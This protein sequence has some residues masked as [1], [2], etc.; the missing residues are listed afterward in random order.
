MTWFKCT[1]VVCVRVRSILPSAQM[2]NE[3]SSK[4]G[5]RSW[6]EGFARNVTKGDPPLPVP[7]KCFGSQK[8][9]LFI[10]NLEGSWFVKKKKMFGEI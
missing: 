2:Q 10:S 9:F 6:Q 8:E 1:W 5:S 4:T 3:A 7:L